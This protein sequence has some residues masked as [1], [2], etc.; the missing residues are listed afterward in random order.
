[1]RHGKYRFIASFLVVPL[2]LYVVFVVS[3]WLVFLLN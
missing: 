1:M 2:V 3:L